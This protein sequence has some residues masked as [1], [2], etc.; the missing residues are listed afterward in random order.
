MAVIV[1]QL[2]VAA[3]SGVL[4]TCNTMTGAQDEM[5]IN[6]SW[7][8]GEAIVSGHVNPDIIKI[9]K[10]S[11]EVQFKEIADKLRMTVP[12]DYGVFEQAVPIELQQQPVLSTEQIACIHQLGMKIEQH[13]RSPQDIEWAIADNKLFVL[14][15][16]PV[17]TRPSIQ[18]VTVPQSELAVPG[19]HEREQLTAHIAC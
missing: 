12:S 9:A 8:L 2:V 4:F 5:I 6:A 13:F 16:R 1:Q 15:A 7:G 18:T 19:D 14:Q 17:T 11:G 3:A 10:E